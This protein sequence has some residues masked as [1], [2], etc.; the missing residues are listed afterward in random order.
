MTFMWSIV[1]IVLLG[2]SNVDVI[3]K[4]FVFVYKKDRFAVLYI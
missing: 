1:F 4:V 3:E 2:G